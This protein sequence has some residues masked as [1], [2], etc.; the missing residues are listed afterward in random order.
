MSFR[1]TSHPYINNAGTVTSTGTILVGPVDVRDMDRFS[2]IY[3]NKNTAI[4][5]LHMEVQGTNDPT[6]SAANTPN[7][8]VAISTATL[9]VPSALGA[10]ASRMSSP[11]NNTY[12]WIRVM[13]YTCQTAAAGTFEVVVQGMMRF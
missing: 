7:P 2:I 1:Y 8:W 6:P 3:K 5:F 9:E 10:T 12:G 11:V 4:T 13:G